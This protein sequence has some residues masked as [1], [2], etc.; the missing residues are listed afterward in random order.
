MNTTTKYPEFTDEQKAIFKEIV[1]NPA[2][3]TKNGFKWTQAFKDHPEWK[4]KILT[5]QGRPMS[6]LWHLSKQLQNGSAPV[7]P[8]YKKPYVSRKARNVE[9]VVVHKR[10]AYKKRKVAWW[11]KKGLPHPS[12]AEAR[13]LRAPVAEAVRRLPT[14]S[15]AATTFCPHCGAHKSHFGNQA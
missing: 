4:Q 8:F 6:H 10:G 15:V 5:D 11:I 14:T 9:L 3:R 13:A 7:R 1:D 12:S 2:Y